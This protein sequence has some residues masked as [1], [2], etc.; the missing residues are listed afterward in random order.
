MI[1]FTTASAS[2]FLIQPPQLLTTA[3]SDQSTSLEQDTSI[4]SNALADSVWTQT[5]HDDFKV[6]NMD[7]TYV[8]GSGVNAD[9][10]LASPT[11]WTNMNPPV[12]QEHGY[13]TDIAT[14]YGTDEILM[15]GGYDYYQLNEL[16]ETWIYDLSSNQWSL[17]APTNFPGGRRDHVMAEVYNTDKVVLWGGLDQRTGPHTHYTDTWVYDLSSNQWTNMNPTISPPQREGPGLSMVYHTDQVVMFGAWGSATGSTATGDET[18]IYDLSAN[19]WTQVFPTSN[20]PPRSHFPM[21]PIYGTTEVILFGGYDGGWN[22]RADTWVYNLTTN[23][24]TQKLPPFSPP[25]M[26]GH[27]MAPIWGDDRV[28][29]LA[30]DPLQTWIYDLSDN[31][32]VQKS[33]NPNPSSSGRL[34]TIYGKQ[35]VV[36]F[37]GFLTNETWLCHGYMP[38]GTF[39]SSSH[40]CDGIADFK[41]IDFSAI[42][43][44][45]TSVEV[46][47][48]SSLIYADLSTQ[49]Y[50]GPD[51]TPASS[52]T[53]LSTPI[54]SGHDGDK[55]IQYKVYLQT[56]N[57]TTTPAFCDIS[58]SYDV[59]SEPPSL[60]SPQTSFPHLTSEWLMDQ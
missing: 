11:H 36:H 16:N 18:F 59:L 53:A 47:F 49:Q 8:N 2:V 48:R 27:T 32:W 3:S 7:N 40:F 37:G 24:W 55:Y 46:R 42:V 31:Q 10:R 50:L 45:S 23:T 15:F 34:A 13:L 43:P 26:A 57:G 22:N 41:T 4:R 30:G 28:L 9:I 20:P 5:T 52:Y 6:G 25:A 56:N 21:T 58:I 1:F 17:K 39:K 14:F 35:E 29:L 38:S 12:H 33:F 44:P 60:I 19:S 51:G 54:W